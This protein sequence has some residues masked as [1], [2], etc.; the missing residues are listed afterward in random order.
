[1]SLKIKFADNTEV[2]YLNAIETEGYWNG[3]SRRT[4]TFEIARTAANVDT[5]DTLCT[6]ANLASLALTNTEDEITNTYDGYVLKLKCGVEPVLIQAETPNAPAAYENR[7][8]LR[9]G[10]RTYIEEQLNTLLGQ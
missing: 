9:L 7:I 8:V 10:K 1:M 6:E 5:L 3:S 4:L 2:E